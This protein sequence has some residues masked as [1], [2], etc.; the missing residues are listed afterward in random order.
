MHVRN[1]FWFDVYLNQ[2]RRRRETAR[3]RAPA[4]S[5]VGGGTNLLVRPPPQTFRHRAKLLGADCQTKSTF[6]LPI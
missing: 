4:L 5:K 1:L 2:E 3:T 6:L